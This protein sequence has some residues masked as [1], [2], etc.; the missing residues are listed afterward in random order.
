M[1]QRRWKPAG[2]L[3]AGS[4]TSLL[5]ACPAWAQSPPADLND[6]IGQEARRI[7]DGSWGRL[8]PKVT[9]S[10]F[11][12]RSAFVDGAYAFGRSIGPELRATVGMMSQVEFERTREGASAL[13][14]L[15]MEG[16]VNRYVSRVTTVEEVLARADQMRDGAWGALPNEAKSDRGQFDREFN[17]LKNALGGEIAVKY[18]EGATSQAM[19][20]ATIDFVI[21]RI[22]GWTRSYAERKVNEWKAAR[23][24]E[25][26]RKRAP[27]PCDQTMRV[28]LPNPLK[29]SCC[30]GRL[31]PPRLPKCTVPTECNNVPDLV[32][33]GACHAR[34]AAKA[35]G[36]WLN[37]IGKA[38]GNMLSNAWNALQNLA[39]GAWEGIKKGAQWVADRAKEAANWVGEQVAKVGKALQEL[40]DKLNIGELFKDP[41]GYLW[42]LLRD[43]ILQPA[44]KFFSEPIEAAKRA[45]ADLVEKAKNEAGKV[46]QEQV[47]VPAIKWAVNKIFGNNAFERLMG[48]A[49]RILGNVDKMLAQAEAVQAAFK[50]LAEKNLQKFDQVMGQVKGHID[51]LKEMRVSGLINAVVDYAQ[52]RLTEFIRAKATDLL[53]SALNMVEGPINAGKAAAV[54]GIGSI[55]FVG[56]VLA[57]AADFV[58]TEGLKTLRKMA[59]DFVINEVVKFVT[60]FLNTV[61]G[62]LKQQGARA[63]AWL[64]PILD[65]LKPI[66]ASIQEKIGPAVAAYEGLAANLAKA[67]ETVARLQQAAGGGK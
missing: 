32:A 63:E 46:L 60:P 44:I 10:R 53:N 45:L 61:A 11:A 20:Q 16:Y 41:V 36:N 58:I 8:P 14:G 56:G 17:D 43:K 27:E 21:A 48:I 51:Q 47:L 1:N 39:K 55:P 31:W 38:I 19:Q 66:V 34:N 35:I 59:V 12:S 6:W 57:G 15:R 22:Q 52:G 54:A 18:P 40:G 67:R 9:G 50:A 13:L 37:D 49:Q 29:T 28:C 24:A 65:A 62:F 2:L 42:R 23:E 30:C 33:R 64:Q 7:A 3:A 26:R 25:E 4:L 5:F